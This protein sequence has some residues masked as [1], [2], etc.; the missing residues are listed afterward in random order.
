MK[1]LKLLALDRFTILLIAMVVL[2]SILPISGQAALI[3]GKITTIAIAILF[4]LHGAKLS[5]E[6]VIEGILHWK[7]HGLV[8]AFTFLVFPLL[9]LMAK[10][11]LEPLLG[12]Q[13]YW[14]FLFMCFLPSTVQSSIAFTSV[15]K[16][17]VAAAVCSASFSNLIGMFITP[18]LVSIFIFG[19]SKHNYDPTSSIIE[20]TLL[21]LVPFVLGQVLRPY[22]FPLMQKMPKIVKVFDQGSILMVVYGAFSGAVVAGLWHQVSLSTLIYLTLACSILLTVIMLLALYVPKWLGFSKADQISIFF[23]GSKKTLASGVPMAQILFIG[24]PLGMIVLPI[25][26]F[27]QIQLMVCG[28]I[29]NYWSKQKHSDE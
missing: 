18:I 3:F 13:L 19:Q 16:G 20:I 9:G 26:I 24:Q 8:F 12:Q 6:A 29:A 7:L 1:M 27:H 22:V 17:N 14:G 21:L 4:F 23:C 2:A 15:A 11:V 28:V 5:R 10:P 25:M